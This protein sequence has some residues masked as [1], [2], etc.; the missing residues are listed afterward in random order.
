[1]IVDLI[2]FFGTLVAAALLSEVFASDRARSGRLLIA[3]LAFCL[4]FE[5]LAFNM[6]FRSAWLELL[7]VLC[8]TGGLG[9]ILWAVGIGHSASPPPSGKGAGCL[10]VLIIPFLPLVSMTTVGRVHHAQMMAE[11]ID[12]TVW[13]KFRSSNHNARSITMAQKDGSTLTVEG[14]DEAMW[15]AVLPGRSRLKKPA[16]SAVGELDGKEVRVVPKRYV[17]FFGP[18][19]D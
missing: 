19:R 18:F 4:G 11:K 3:V 14:V 7:C 17:M 12:G 8:A 2:A 16:W 13:R 9:M 15:N 5:I 1:M 6:P 10:F